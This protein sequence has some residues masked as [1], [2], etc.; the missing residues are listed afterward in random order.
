M[1]P[2]A[3]RHFEAA[4]S[5]EKQMYWKGNIAHLRFY[6][7]SSVVDPTA[8]EVAAFFRDHSQKAV[9]E[10]LPDTVAQSAS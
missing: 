4:P 9:V 5:I 10:N 1:P 6:D 7:D 3:K 8:Q 2:A